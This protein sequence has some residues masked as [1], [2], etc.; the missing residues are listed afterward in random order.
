M[1][2]FPTALEEAAK[3]LCKAMHGNCDNARFISDYYTQ[4]A[5]AAI[6]AS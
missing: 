1:T 5:T 4:H 6:T 2:L 3:A